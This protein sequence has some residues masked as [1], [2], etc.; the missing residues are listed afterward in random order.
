MIT[1]Q[2]LENQEEKIL[3]PYACLSKYSQ[4]R[5]Y[6]EIASESRTEFQRDRDRVIHAKA[7]R[8]LLHKT[9]VFV[10]LEGDHY[11]N[12]LTHTLEVSQIGRH[13][14][15]ILR[16]NEDL[17]ETIALA[18]DLGHTPFGHTGEEIL[19]ELMKDHGGFEHNRQSRKIVEKLEK[20]YVGIDGLNLTYE[21]LD[22]LIKHRSPYDNSG[23]ESLEGP[24]LEAQ[25]VN[26][27]DEIAYNSH[28]TDDGITSRLLDMNE[29]YAN[30]TIWKELTDLH[31]Q[32]YSNLSASELQN[33]NIRKLIHYQ[34]TDLVN[35]SEAN[36]K[37]QK[38]NSYQDVLKTIE[39]LI[40]FSTE[41]SEK[42]QE[43]RNYLYNNFYKHPVILSKVNEAQHIIEKLFNYYKKH[44][45]EI[46]DSSMHIE[47]ATVEEAVCDYIAGMTDQYARKKFLNITSTQKT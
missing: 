33:L 7:F 27:A 21:T 18:H 23:I 35:N 20:K 16:L 15:R 26:I 8:R 25:A 47:E 31:Q 22:G 36:L 14:A 45:A 40:I 12:R 41:T 28:D 11:R 29:L 19:D 39:P 32:S 38:I 34:I 13:I 44:P 43:L 2:E 10:A 30:V 4:G 6:Q 46:K 5:K 24:S 37:L 1:K 17:A 9:Q 3:A 42:I